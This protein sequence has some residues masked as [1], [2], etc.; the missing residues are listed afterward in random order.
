MSELVDYKYSYN[1]EH[2]PPLY[3]VAFIHTH[4]GYDIVSFIAQVIQLN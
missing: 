2:L 1:F 4:A 3:I